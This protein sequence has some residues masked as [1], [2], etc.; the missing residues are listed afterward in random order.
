MKI[1]ICGDRNWTDRK[2]IKRIIEQFHPTEI[3]EGEARGADSI[4]R[5]VG[6]ELGIIVHKYPANWKLYGKAAGSIRNKQMLDEGKPDLVM[7]FHNDLT[8]SKGTKNML[9][10]SRKANVRTYLFTNKVNGETTNHK[11]SHFAKDIEIRVEEKDAN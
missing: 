3:I 7:A 8:N 5:D 2:F 10:I 6:E 1:L 9:E 11:V 4:A